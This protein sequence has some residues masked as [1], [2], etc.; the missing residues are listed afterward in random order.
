[1]NGYSDEIFLE[2]IRLIAKDLN[3]FYNELTGKTILVAGGKGFLGTYFVNVLNQINETLSKP[4]KI[5]IIDN[6]I[7]AKDK[8]K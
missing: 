6:L 2:D 3:S 8:K 1:M 7:T 4:M 5:V